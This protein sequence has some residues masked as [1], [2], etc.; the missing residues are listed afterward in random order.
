EDG[1]N[2]YLWFVDL[3]GNVDYRNHQVVRLLYDSSLP[4]FK[5][6][7]VLNADFQPYWYNQTSTLAAQIK[8]NY[9]ERHPQKLRLES[10]GLDTTVEVEELSSG[11][12]V[13][14]L[15][16]IAIQGKSDGIYDLAFTLIDSAGNLAQ[17]TSNIALDS[18]PPV[19]TEA[20][21]PDTSS[22]ESFV[23]TWGNTATDGNGSGL[24]GIYDVKVQIDGGIWLNWLTNFAGTL[25]EFQ[26][27]HGQTY[28]FEAVAH[29]NV[30]NIEVFSQIPE[31]VTHVD[32]S[33]FDNRPPTVFHTPTL[34]VEEGKGIDIQV[35][36][37]DNIQVIEA[38]LFYKQSG[39]SDYQTME[40]TDLGGG[41][42]Q[43]TLTAAQISTKGINYYIR[44]SDGINFA[45]HPPENWDIW[46][47]NVS[48]RI[49]GTNNQGL[50]KEQSQP[51][52]S[53]Q[54]A[55]RMISMPLILDDPRPQTVLEDDLGPYD[56]KQWRLFQFN[57]LAGEYSEFPNLDAFLPGKAFWLI[58]REP[59]KQIDSG[60]GTTVTTNQSFQIFLNQGWNDIGNPFGFPV[61][62]S[63]V[64][65][66]QG[67]P[68]DIM[69]PYTFRDQWLLP[70][71]VT[72]LS[73]WEGYSVYSL[74]QGAVISI[75]PIEIDNQPVHTL[76]KSYHQANWHL[77][78][79]AVCQEALDGTNFLGVST[80]ALANWDK[81]DYLEPPYIGDYVSLRFPHD[82]WQIYRGAF[83]TD[84]RPPFD[85]GQVWHFEVQTNILNAPI[86]LKFQKL[87]SLPSYFRVLLFDLTTFQQID[88]QQNK[89]YNFI[90]DQS[91]LS[92]EFDLIIGTN[93][94]VKNSDILKETIPKEFSL[95][96]NFPNPFNAG[97]TL[98]Y[99]I[100][101]ICHVSIKVLNILGQEVRQLISQ[102]QVP[103]VYK[104]YWDGKS[105]ASK[106]I[107][108]GLYIIKFEA[109]HFQ[110]SR[111][112]LLIR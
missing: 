81:L 16:N 103:G 37:E 38:T 66:V 54:S 73:P 45:F 56:S 5:G 36:I 11:E 30:G 59:N 78:I 111:K 68:N 67:N 77:G 6:F 35:Q 10:V 71:Q 107:G 74:I 64:E 98:F 108:S 87:E 19:G 21:S 106:E 15:F 33:F 27:A 65:V 96:Q 69:G 62:W 112:V 51:G 97:T 90:P 110:Q 61:N 105:D 82:E 88:V 39:K 58:V 32:T 7:E 43:A 14:S 1:Q 92:R 24:S 18:T 2:F 49:L 31:S 55:F 20:S 12:N 79:E 80:N 100:P 9:S 23:V 104:V 83:T 63:D 50:I 34:V 40:M 101:D 44:A 47:N 85:D 102:R 86:T 89:E 41:I 3:R 25:A 28:G 95:S 42:Y 99:Q 57:S 109:G 91:S 29:D 46:P 52:G 4:Q 75:S 93:S 53:T 17:D 76:A 26:G 48:V 8:I 94:Y 72:T 60:V 70:N 84:F 13:S 22:E